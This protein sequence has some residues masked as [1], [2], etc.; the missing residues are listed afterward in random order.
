[1]AQEN[2]IVQ[3]GMSS[4]ELDALTLGESVSEDTDAEAKAA[5]EAAEALKETETE[6]EVDP[7]DAV[8]GDFRRKAR[9]L[10]LE[11]AKLAGQLE[12]RK[13]LQTETKEEVTPEKSPLEIA[14][15][16][17]VEENGDLDGFA[18][19]GALYREQAAF[20]KANDQ[21]EREVVESTRT[22][23]T[24]EITAANLQ[25]GDLSPE[26]AGEGLDLQSMC[27]L[28]DKY[29]TNGDNLDLAEL[30]Q[31]KGTAVALKEAYKI[32]KRRVLESGT[33]DSAT[34]QKA[35]DAKA[36]KKK[37]PAKKNNEDDIDALTTEEDDDLTQ[38]DDDAPRVE[39]LTN[40]IFG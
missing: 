40:F 12:A 4:E 19:T 21:K 1:M 25:E 30:Q 33:E 32:M 35:I 10:E 11:N 34:L 5:L 13:E 22:K 17:Y 26:T 9:D 7:K 20:D 24:M 23:S 27:K 2:D 28:G 18:M 15:A 8:I 31:A 3:E 16:A 38:V 39:R 29:L 6:E 14:E 37:V 36:G